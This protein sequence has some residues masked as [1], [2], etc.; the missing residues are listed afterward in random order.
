MDLINLSKSILDFPNRIPLDYPSV[1]NLINT[2]TQDI[3][4]IFNGDNTY[5][6]L[7]KAKS[8]NKYIV[9]ISARFDTR[10]GHIYVSWG[11]ELESNRICI[12]DAGGFG[13]YPTSKNLLGKFYGE[14]DIFS[15]AEKH[16]EYRN[17]K[18]KNLVIYLDKEIYE[19]T[20]YLRK[21]WEHKED[22]T[23]FLL[24]RNCMTFVDEIVRK[25]GLKT[26]IEELNDF[27]TLPWVY[28]Q[29]LIDLN[30]NIEEK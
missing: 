16:P 10:V 22:K 24:G 20:E 2:A 23:Y 29:K 9:V 27:I 30:R 12:T 3:F 8:S 25:I 11:R 28:L 15:E 17:V 26:P 19:Q 21:Y 14:G 4:S 13:Y 5:I 7:S 18:T 1:S 6:N